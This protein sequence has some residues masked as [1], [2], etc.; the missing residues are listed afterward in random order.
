MINVPNASVSSTANG[1]AGGV[2]G[3]VGCGFSCVGGNGGSANAQASGIARDQATVSA[4]ATGGNGGQRLCGGAGANGGSATLSSGGLGPAVFGSSATGGTVTVSGTAIGGAG[5]STIDSNVN[6]NGASV[7]LISN[8]GV[9]D[10]IGGATSGTL[11]LT[12]TAIGGNGGCFARAA[13]VAVHQAHLLELTPTEPQPIISMPMQLAG[14]AAAVGGSA[15][16]TADASASKGG[17]A[18]ATANAKGGDG[19]LFGN[20]FGF[21]GNATANASATNGGSA[22][23]QAT[24]GSGFWTGNRNRDFYCDA[25]R[26]RKRDRNSDGRR[27]RRF[28]ELRWCKRQLIRYDDQWQC[29][30]GEVLCHWLISWRRAGPGNRTDQFRKFHIGSIYVHK[31]R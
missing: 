12:Q 2:V 9:N 17:I 13:L 27:R 4:I 14:M 6:G 3:S 1:G 15:T 26:H 23:A 19:N 21:G 7:S 20:G 31:P 28:L 18:N 25:G 22:V 29:G 11:N 24:G 30:P 10:A 16:A 5:G 8:G